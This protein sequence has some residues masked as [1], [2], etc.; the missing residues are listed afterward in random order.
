LIDC[1]RAVF[2][3]VSGHAFS[4]VNGDGAAE[5]AATINDS[6]RSRYS[7]REA[8]PATGAR[9]LKRGRRG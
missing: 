6:C 7:R 3:F 5:I 9:A 2:P 1:S 4:F 8:S